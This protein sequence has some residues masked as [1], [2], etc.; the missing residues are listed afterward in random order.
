MLA[1]FRPTLGLS[2]RTLRYAPLPCPLTPLPEP[3][4]SCSAATG[5]HHTEGDWDHDSSHRRQY[6][7][8]PHSTDSQAPASGF[9]TCNQAGKFTPEN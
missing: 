8:L 4:P 9:S 5:S 3:A 7:P 6:A 1:L 2:T